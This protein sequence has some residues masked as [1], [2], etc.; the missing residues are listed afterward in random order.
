MKLPELDTLKQEVI[1]IINSTLYERLKHI[2]N[3]DEIRNMV[4]GERFTI[5][6][7]IAKRIGK[8]LDKALY[9]KFKNKRRK[10]QI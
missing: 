2:P 9:F 5:G 8:L 4:E 10:S 1:E 6:K 3:E 7:E